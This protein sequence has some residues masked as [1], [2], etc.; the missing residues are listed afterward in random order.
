MGQGQRST[1]TADMLGS[2]NTLTVLSLQH[3]YR[4]SPPARGGGGRQQQDG[5]EDMESGVQQLPQL[6]QTSQKGGVLRLGKLLLLPEQTP[7][8]CCC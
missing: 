3:T 4:R 8:V 2:A 6:L 1:V 7:C 5:T